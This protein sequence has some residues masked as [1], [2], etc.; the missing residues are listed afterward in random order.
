MT[1]LIAALGIGLNM[2]AI[3][4]FVAFSDRYSTEGIPNFKLLFGFLAVFALSHAVTYLAWS[5]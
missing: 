3:G 5:A 4:A 1:A 2:I